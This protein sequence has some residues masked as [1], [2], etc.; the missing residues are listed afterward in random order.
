MKGCFAENRHMMFFLKLS[1]ERACNGS[2]EWMLERKCDVWKEY[3]YI[4]VDNGFCSCIHLPCLL[5]RSLLVVT[6]HRKNHQRT[7]RDNIAPSSCICRLRRISGA[8]CFL[9]HGATATGSFFG[10]VKWTELQITKN[11]FILNNSLYTGP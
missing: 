6:S 3:M 4:P 11:C 2:L 1:G 10:D 8:W 5:H 7:S 9:L